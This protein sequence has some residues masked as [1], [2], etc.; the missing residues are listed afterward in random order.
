MFLDLFFLIIKGIYTSKNNFVFKYKLTLFSMRYE[1]LIQFRLDDTTESN[2]SLSRIDAFHFVRGAIDRHY[3]SLRP[4]NAGGLLP[5]SGEDKSHWNH[6]SALFSFSRGFVHIN[7]LYKAICQRPY[8]IE[9]KEPKKFEQLLVIN[10]QSSSMSAI[11]VISEAILDKI[12]E[13][14]PNSRRM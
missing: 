12:Q 2:L 6:M 11:R 3:P 7:H 10:S 1:D 13:K 4:I 14:F 8:Q 5:Y 9:L